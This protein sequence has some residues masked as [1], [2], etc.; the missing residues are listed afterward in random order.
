[1]GC[2]GT[3]AKATGRFTQKITEALL[4]VANVVAAA[5]R[6]G[7]LTVDRSIVEKRLGICKAC[8]HLQGSKCEVCGCILA[9]KAGLNGATCPIKKW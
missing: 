8:P 6:S 9:V 1:M 3:S 5:S 2:C 7:K 4:T